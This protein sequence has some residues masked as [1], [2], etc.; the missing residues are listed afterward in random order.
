MLV[1]EQQHLVCNITMI[2]VTFPTIV[3]CSTLRI[4][5][6][7]FYIKKL[8]QFKKKWKK[9]NVTTLVFEEMTIYFYGKAS[10]KEKATIF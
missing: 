10:R 6:N 2:R 4:G 5:P 9:L 1:Y 7:L 8:I 3:S